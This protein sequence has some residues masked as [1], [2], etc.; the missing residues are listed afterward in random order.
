M[1]PVSKEKKEAITAIVHDVSKELGAHDEDLLKGLMRE[2]LSD[3]RLGRDENLRRH[4]SEWFEVVFN[5]LNDPLALL[6]E[7]KEAIQ[8]L[9]TYQRRNQL[10]THDLFFS[11]KTY[12]Y[13]KYLNKVLEHIKEVY[14][15]SYEM[16]RDEV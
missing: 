14:Q 4:E 8:K 2:V 13:L 10:E 9:V 5:V 12:V 1:E 6:R 11:T 16:V 7:N 15:E 3:R